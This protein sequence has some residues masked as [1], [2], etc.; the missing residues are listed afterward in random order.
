MRRGRV[1][2]YLAFIL[3]LGLVAVAVVYTRVIAPGR[4]AAQQIVITVTPPPPMVLAANR[5]LTQGTVLSE[6]L[7]VPME[8]PLEDNKV[9]VAMF[10]ATEL[11]D[12]IGRVLTFDI[13]EG[14]IILDTML[15]VEGE[16]SPW[17]LKIEDKGVAVSIPVSRLSG[18]SFAPRTGDQ[19]DIIATLLLVDVDT[20][21]QTILPNLTGVVIASGPPDPDTKEQNPLTVDVSSLSQEGLPDSTGAYLPSMPIN[22]GVFGRVVIDPVLGQAIYIVPSEKQR[23]RLVSQMVVRK[24]TV[25]QLG[26][27][28]LVVASPTPAVPGAQ[29]TPGANQA[30]L[31]G[32]PTQAPEKPIEPETITLIVSPQH[33]IALNYLMFSGA[34]LTLALRSPKND[35][36]EGFNAVTLQYLLENYQIPVPVRLPYQVQPRLDVL[37]QPTAIPQPTARP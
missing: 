8:A 12:L 10:E 27:F 13:P 29:L 2:F 24:A 36:T 14:T 20:E 19:V 32:Q 6:D 26:D 34:Q 9:P 23:P 18:V 16:G 22:P 4:Q 5:A 37:A 7:L 31:Q 3:I 25:L 17:A 1:F 11:Q 33:A 28:P 15:L 35:S 30:V 21:F